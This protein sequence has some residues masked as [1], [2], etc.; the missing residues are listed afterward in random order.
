[1]NQFPKEKF[2]IIIPLL[3]YHGKNEWITGNR[4]TDIMNGPKKELSPYIPDFQFILYDLSNYSDEEIKGIVT[5][6]ISLLL[7]KYIFH[8]HLQE[9]LKKIFSL[10]RE[11][12]D[13]ETGLEFL[14]TVIRYLFSTTSA[15]TEKELQAI[16]EETLSKEIGGTVMTIAEKLIEKGREEGIL[17][18]KYETIEFGLLLR[19][20]EAGLSLMPSIRNITNK[21][22]LDALKDAIKKATDIWDIRKVLKEIIQEK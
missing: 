17:L 7:F 11:L 13:K 18:E 12:L 16:I 2:P 6:K 22:Q 19:F 20:G 9:E 1:M 4:L 14:E 21:T 5:L 15:V 3:I 10:F 8:P